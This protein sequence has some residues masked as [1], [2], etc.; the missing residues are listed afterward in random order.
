MPNVVDALVT[1][2]VWLV[3]ALQKIKFSF[4]IL[5]FSV[6]KNYLLLADKNKIFR[7]KIF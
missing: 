3:V 1:F 7:Y 4:P 2:T 6:N 5:S